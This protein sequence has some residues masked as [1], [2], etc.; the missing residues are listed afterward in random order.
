VA[1][2]IYTKKTQQHQLLKYSFYTTFEGDLLYSFAIDV[3]P[4]D[5]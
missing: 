2:L 4:M 5:Y 1:S 3:M